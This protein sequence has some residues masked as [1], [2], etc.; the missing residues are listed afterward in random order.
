MSPSTP[1]ACGSTLL[2]LPNDVMDV[3]PE[4][5]KRVVRNAPIHIE[6]ST[7]D[8]ENSPPVVTPYWDPSVDPKRKESRGRLIELIH[9]LVKVGLVA[10]RTRRRAD[11]GLFFPRKK[12]GRLRMVLDARQANEYHRPPPHTSLASVNALTALDFG[13]DF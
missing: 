6:Q 5:V 1:R 13:D 3:A 4:H 11:I 7:E 10:A 12:E 8:I 9:A 2:T